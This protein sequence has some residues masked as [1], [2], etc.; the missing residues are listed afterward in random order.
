V[1][2]R[3]A[4]IKDLAFRFRNEVRAE[5]LKHRGS[6]AAG[7]LGS[8]V[9]NI[10]AHRARY[11]KKLDAIRA[12]ADAET[13]FLAD[14]VGREIDA[15][16]T[17]EIKRVRDAGRVEFEPGATGHRIPLEIHK[18]GLSDNQLEVIM[19][20]AGPLAKETRQEF[21]QKVAA[22]LPARGQI[23]DDDVSVAMHRALS[24]IIRN[25]GVERVEPKFA[26]NAP[27]RAGIRRR[28]VSTR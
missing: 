26:S 10:E 19:R 9:V 1:N 4:E 7:V 21:L 24:D 3:K 5:I 17:K 27:G 14:E 23:N 16:A 18:I 11:A 25:G 6:K 13:I 2:V 15:L 8:F 20:T 12:G 28:L 22:I